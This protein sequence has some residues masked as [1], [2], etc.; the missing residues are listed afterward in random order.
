MTVHFC[1]QCNHTLDGETTEACPNCGTP[2]SDG[3]WPRDRRLGKEVVGGQYRVLRRLGRG[4]FGVVYLVETVLGGLKRALK[5]L[6]SEWAT[7]PKVRE[8]FVQEAVLLEGVNHPNVARCYAAGTMEDDQEL[9]LLF[10]LVD[11]VQLSR[12]LSDAQAQGHSGLDPVRAVKLAKQVASGLV[13]AHASRVLHRDLKPENL[14]VVDEGTENEQIKIVDFGIAKALDRDGLSTRHV[15][16]TPEYLAPEQLR[17]GNELDARV[18]LWQLGATLYCLLTGRPAFELEG[19]GMVELQIQQSRYMEE[20][21]A[22]SLMRPALAAWPGLD[23]LVQ[24]LLASD[25]SMRP[26]SAAQVCE[27]LA[28]LEHTM[29]PGDGNT[30]PLGLLEALCAR[31]S[32]Q[33][34]WALCRFLADI[35]SK[36]E[37]SGLVAAAESLLASWPDVL[38]RAPLSWWETVKRG[39]AHPLWPLARLLDL[40]NRGLSDEDTEDLAACP[41]M[42]AITILDLSGNGIGFLGT[43]ALALSVHLPS[44]KSLVLSENRIGPKG[45]EVL[46]ASMELTKLRSLI[47]DNNAVGSRGAEAI[48]SARLELQEIDLSGS[49]IG[50]SGAAAIANSKRLTQL[51]KLRVADADLG[52]DGA[53]AIA[54]SHELRSLRE[55]DLSGNSIGPGGAAAIALS[56]KLDSLERLSLA[57]NQLG[58]EGVELLMTTHRFSRLESLDLSSNSIG[59]RGAMFLAS[60]PFSR[61]LK[62]L[63]LSD[64]GL[65]D[66]GVASLLGAA[67]LSGL[68]SLALAQNDLTAAGAALLGGIPPELQSLDVS[69]SKLG[70]AGATSLIN[71]LVDHPPARAQ[72]RTLRPGPRGQLGD[73]RPPRL[74]I[75][76]LSLAANG[77][78]IQG[79]ESAEDGNGAVEAVTARRP[80]QQVDLEVAVCLWPAAWRGSI[81]RPTTWESRVP[82][83][84]VTGCL[85]TKGGQGTF[86]PNLESPQPRAQ[87]SG[88]SRL[89]SVG[90]GARRRFRSSKHSISPTTGSVPKQRQRWPTPRSPSGSAS[91]SSPTAGWV[92]PASR[93]WSRTPPGRCSVRSICEATN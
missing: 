52:S 78:V 19:D 63:D 40:S 31:P 73:P 49:D 20:G 61:R 89:R 41:E 80:T 38:R 30:G 75:E 21:P 90:H 59:A 15:V 18:D 22:P 47:L 7:E 27:E 65:G 92:M 51:E 11:G 46:A 76:S 91:S 83:A 93:R 6:H 86:L 43:E 34:W 12:V 26:R 79:P 58:V 44:L 45:L 81:F 71:S 67:H 53:S 84:F 87:H 37:Q 85:R 88:R 72:A 55:L 69:A 2:P 74:P 9:Y 5:V 33:G 8:R 29:T 23:R 1:H 70:I 64:N 56:P 36:D 28:R 68:N 39:E 57:R 10:E 82:A 62:H 42:S 25:R 16:G 77:I 14:L 50:P 24:R 66:A 32:E 3:R 60:S 48:A 13:A 4:G 54:V 17:P 35:E